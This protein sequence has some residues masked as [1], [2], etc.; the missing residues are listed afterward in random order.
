LD[1][2][3]AGH[4]ILFRYFTAG[5]STKFKSFWFEGATIPLNCD[6]WLLLA[7]RNS[8][9]RALDFSEFSVAMPLKSFSKG[10]HEFAPDPSRASDINAMVR[11]QTSQMQT[12]GGI[13]G[14]AFYIDSERDG[15]VDIAMDVDKD[16]IHMVGTLRATLCP[17]R[18]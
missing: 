4:S 7:D 1:A 8:P 11:R 14:G 12:A 6:R 13:N 2:S 5:R 15:H 9:E 16:L 18:D 3:F 17:D 10:R